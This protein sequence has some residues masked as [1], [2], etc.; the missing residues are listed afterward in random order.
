MHR[1]TYGKKLPPARLKWPEGKPLIL[2]A[3]L[4]VIVAFYILDKILPPILHLLVGIA[5]F[6]AIHNT[7]HPY[8]VLQSL[9]A[10]PAARN[11]LLGLIVTSI[12]LMILVSLYYLIPSIVLFLILTPLLE[13][14]YYRGKTISHANPNDY[15]TQ[16]P[17]DSYEAP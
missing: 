1:A 9:D 13:K 2:Y 5:L 17:R 12:L 10:W 15:S 16:P 3:P 7:L 11:L 6:I 8:D 4:F 14:R